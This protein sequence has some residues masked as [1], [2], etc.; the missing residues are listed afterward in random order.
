LM[1]KNTRSI[2]V[3]VFLAIASGISITVG[4]FI[5]ASGG[6][7]SPLTLPALLTMMFSPALGAILATKLVEHRSLRTNGIAKG[8]LKY[9]LLAWAYP[10]IFILIGLVFITLLGTGT[11]NFSNLAT[12]VPPTPGMS[13]SIM[14]ILAGVNLLLAPFINFIPALGEEYG[15]RGFLQ[16]TLIE[17]FGLTSGLTL[18]GLIW[19]LWHAP[20][21]LQGYNYPQH[22]DLI[23]VSFFT[24]WTILV[25]YFLGWVRIKS[26]S[27]LPAALGHGAINAY[28]GFGLILAPAKDELLG[29]PLGLPAFLALALIAALLLRDL[30]KR[31]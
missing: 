14:L 28:V 9:Y 4:A 22:P 12:A 25:G 20:I 30:R 8:R 11:V 5:L 13:S 29:L 15:W 27:C 23:G 24:L 3:L 1:V 2:S 10:I 21:I 19:G 31:T 16:P 6:L 17:R 26:N 7:R 18:T